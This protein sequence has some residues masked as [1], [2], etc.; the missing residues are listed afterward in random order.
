VLAIIGTICDGWGVSFW[1]QDHWLVAPGKEISVE[2]R[3]TTNDYWGAQVA[4]PV[5][6]LASNEWLEVTGHGVFYDFSNGTFRP[7]A[8]LKN[9]GTES[10]VFQL[11]GGGLT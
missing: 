6:Y 1:Q 2:Y 8:T 9:K 4:M 10:A 7:W 11:R 5:P 3:V